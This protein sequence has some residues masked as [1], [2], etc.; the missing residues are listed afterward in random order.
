MKISSLVG[1]FL[2]AMPLM[3]DPRFAR[4][5]VYMCA[6]NSTGAMGIVTNRLYGA[7]DSDGLFEQLNIE[8]S[9]RTTD[10]P[11]H[12]GGPVETGR[13]FVLHTDDV[14]LEGS[15]PIEGDIAMT[16]TLEILKAV[17]DGT[18]PLRCLVSLGYAGWSPGQIEAELQAGAWLTVP[19]ST[20]LLFDANLETKWER[21]LAVLGITPALL[22][23]Q[24]GRA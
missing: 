3:D 7:I 22:S 23:N 13:G 17:A 11:I 10:L 16:A 20:A 1:Q 18:G 19:G 15:M 24:T 2:V 9:Y 6:H 14:M 5:V 21:T 8:P 4:T 12:Y